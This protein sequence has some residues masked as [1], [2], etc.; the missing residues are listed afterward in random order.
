MKL[1]PYFILFFICSCVERKNNEFKLETKTIMVQDS[2]LN[3]VI[4]NNIKEDE[5]Q[6]DS[7]I[8]E[9][10]QYNVH[11]DFNNLSSEGGEGYAFY[12]LIT[13]KIKKAEIVLYSES[14][15]KKIELIFKDS[16][17][18]I[19]ET[20]YKYQNSITEIKSYSDMKIQKPIF[21][22]LD[23]NG[24]IIGVENKDKLDFYQEF[25]NL[26]PFNL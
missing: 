8:V 20:D 7:P 22:M 25:K 19:K 23:F 24:H 5:N 4:S 13:K 15:Q 12:E 18:K 14:E 1:I 21:Y 9:K 6:I 10:G 3:N 26:V 16:I 11:F 17:I 2:N